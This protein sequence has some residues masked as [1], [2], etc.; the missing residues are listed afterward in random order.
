MIPDALAAKLQEN[1]IDLA[2]VAKNVFT[3]V[4]AFG[5]VVLEAIPMESGVALNIRPSYEARNWG[6]QDTFGRV[7]WCILENYDF[8]AKEDYEQIRADFANVW[9]KL[10]SGVE[11]SVYKES[12][13]SEP[14]RLYVVRPR[15]SACRQHQHE[16]PV[17]GCPPP[18]R[19]RILPTS[20][21]PTTSSPPRSS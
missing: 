10:D 1:G 11:L 6:P 3:V 12:K 20:I 16:W 4:C 9:K 21:C 7:P 8:E 15:R 5:R 19:C 13:D 2:S 14:H 17:A 18:C